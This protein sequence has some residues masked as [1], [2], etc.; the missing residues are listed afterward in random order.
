MLYFNKKK[1]SNNKLLNNN[2]HIFIFI[3]RNITKEDK[4]KIEYIVQD[5]NY[6][7]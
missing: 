3:K 1:L 4:N 7:R 6:S 5:W 2:N